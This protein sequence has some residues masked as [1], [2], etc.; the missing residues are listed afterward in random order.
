MHNDCILSDGISGSDTGTYDKASIFWNDNEITKARKYGIE[1]VRSLRG[2][3]S[4]P[5]LFSNQM[6][7]ADLLSFVKVFP[8]K[9]DNSETYRL[10]YLNVEFPPRVLALYKSTTAANVTCIQQIQQAL[11][12]NG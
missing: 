11:V 3:E 1:Q 4:C 9:S 5:G 2:G 10:S 12:M 6:E 8:S 7:C